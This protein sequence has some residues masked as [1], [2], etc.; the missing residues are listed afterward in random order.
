MLRAA[1]T[2]FVLGLVTII[3]GANGVGGLSIDIGKILL[4]VFIILSIISL[5]GN[6][7]VKK[8]IS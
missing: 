7:L 6:I 5:I 4:L 1:L 8:K 2:F 3:L